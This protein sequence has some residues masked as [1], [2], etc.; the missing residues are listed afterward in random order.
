MPPPIGTPAGIVLIVSISSIVF[1][2][3]GF[4]LGYYSKFR[5]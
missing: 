2:I 4:L 3:L 5:K 1:G